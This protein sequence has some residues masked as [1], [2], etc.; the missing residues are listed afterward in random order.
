MLNIHIPNQEK[1]RALI[2]IDLQEGFLNDKSRWIIP[3]IQQIIKDGKYD[4]IVETVFHADPGSLWDKQ[5]KWTFPLVETTP[6]IKALLDKD[7]VHIIKTTK[8]AF[9]GNK[10]LLNILKS[11]NIDTVHVT[12]IDTD[13]CVFA[14]AQE[15]FDLGFSTYVLEEC[16]ASSEGDGYRDAALKLLRNVQMTNYTK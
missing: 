5:V 2:L 1:S 9:K 14:T 12:G 13:D 4:L 10:D 6:E 3:N 15:S 16:T 8:S 7:V 11:K